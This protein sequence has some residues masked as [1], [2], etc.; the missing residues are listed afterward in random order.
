MRC[1]T[2]NKAVCDVTDNPVSVWIL[3]VEAGSVIGVIE[4]NVVIAGHVAVSQ[5]GPAYT[6]NYL[7]QYSAKV[8]Y[9][10]TCIALNVLNPWLYFL[11]EPQRRVVKSRL[12]KFP[13][14]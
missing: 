2:D 9:Y 11:T 7:T 1:T 12:Q 8:I 3:C 14:E 4:R 5:H 13:I 6:V 10:I